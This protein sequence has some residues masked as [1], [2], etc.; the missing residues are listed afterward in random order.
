MSSGGTARPTLVLLGG[1][2]AC[3]TAVIMIKAS[4]TH[5]FA[6]S[7]F[8]LLVAGI[9]LLPLFLRAWRR[10]RAQVTPRD[11]ARALLPGAFLALHFITWT[12]GARLTL[13]ANASL[14]VNMV[15]V[16]MP[17]LLHTMLGEAISR[18]ERRGTALAMA[19]VIVLGA[20]AARVSLTTLAGDAICLLS[21]LLFAVYLI[22]GRINRHLPSIWLYVVPLYLGAGLICLV[23]ALPFTPVFQ[24]YPVR[25]IALL[26]GLGLVP[27]VLGHSA[28]MRAM[29]A[30]PPQ[31]VA[32]LNLGQFVFGALLA[33]WFF[34]EVP[35]PLFYAA[36]VLLLGGA[37]TAIRASVPPPT[38]HGGIDGP[39]GG[40]GR[41]SSTRRS[42]GGTSTSG[43]SACARR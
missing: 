8:R 31:R 5:A 11:L 26:L 18:G 32:I 41:R 30:L 21:M 24:P 23:V 40:S 25:E 22:F 34:H 1:V 10:H 4:A 9:A 15:P 17:L 35:G 19:G 42:M 38:D 27:T 33:W 2:F 43:S 20:S 13:A 6:L 36:T 14:I 28:L 29:K 37:V 16:A 7:A 3:S 39:S 12:I